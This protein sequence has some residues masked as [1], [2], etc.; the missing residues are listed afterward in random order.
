MPNNDTLLIDGGERESSD[1]ILSI[2]NELT[3]SEIDA[4]VATH[5]HADDIGG[6]IDVI[7]NANARQVIDSGQMHTTQTFEDLLDAVYTAQIPL[8]S[9]HEGDS[10]DIN[11]R[12]DLD[13]LNPPASLLVG[14]N[15]ENEFNDNSVLIK[16]KYG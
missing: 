2:L 8:R 9:V 14:A 13:V 15:N 3:I 16:L 10:I 6:L 12:V 5:P 7:K 1:G 4:L 11:P